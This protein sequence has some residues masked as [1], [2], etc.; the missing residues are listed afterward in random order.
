MGLRFKNSRASKTYFSLPRVDGKNYPE[1]VTKL[2]D[3]LL[4]KLFSLLS[5][6]QYPRVN[7]GLLLSV[8]PL[9]KDTHSASGEG[10]FSRVKAR[11]CHHTAGSVY[12]LH[13]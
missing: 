10:K 9:V 8:F 6:L 13:S 3:C 4:D 12:S 5:L 1:S 7:Q 2:I 11:R